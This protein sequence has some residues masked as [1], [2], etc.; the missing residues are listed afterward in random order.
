M[1]VIVGR[2]ASK[3]RLAKLERT[4]KQLPKDAYQE[5]RKE[6]PID[7]GN[8]KRKTDLVNQS[9][10]ANYPYATRLENGYSR[11]ASDGMSKPTIEHIRDIIR[12][13]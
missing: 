9:I 10:K 12:R 7:T 1:T 8:A 13:V 11:Q 5:F 3:R 4:F 6:T 2:I